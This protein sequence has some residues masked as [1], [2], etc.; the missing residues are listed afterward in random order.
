MQD[1]AHNPFSATPILQELYVDGFPRGFGETLAAWGALLDTLRMVPVNGFPYIQPVPFDVPGPDG[2]KTPE[3]LG[4]E[5]GRRTAVAEAAF[6]NKIWRD[7]MRYWDEELKPASIAKHTELGSVDLAK[8]DDEELRA[9]LHR[10]VEHMQAMWYQH[11]RYNG[12][13]LVPVADFCLHAAAWTGRPP[14]SLLA[15]FDGYSPVSS[16]LSPEVAPAVAAIRN[17]PEALAI[18]DGQDPPDQRLAAL[19][20]RLPEVDE[21][22]RV[23]G[24]RLA[25]GFDLNGLTVGELPDLALGRL[26]AG[27]THDPDES[28]RRADALVATLRSELPAEHQAEFDDLLAEGRL[29]YRLRDERGLYSDAAAVG[30]MRLALIELGTRLYE[31]G[32]IGFKYDALDLTV[33]EIDSVLDGAASPTAD[34]LAARVARRKALNKMGAPPFLGEPPPPP[35]PVDMLPPPLARVMSAFG[36]AIDGVLGE[37]EA[38]AG[39]DVSVHGIAGAAGVVEGPARLVRNFDDLLDIEDGDVIVAKATGESFNSFLHMA[40]AIV[41]D[42]GSYASHAAIMGREMGLPAVVG[43]GNATSRI[44]NGARIRVDGD[45]GV[46]TIL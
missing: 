28:K 16:V 11:H 44:P 19:R 26:E 12:H 30:L 29:V 10:C 27:L 42:H 21:Y 24:F 8:L 23:V 13:A 7:V 15:V 18:L 34:E 3:Y 6:A 25:T 40:V 41:T 17:D 43:T 22:M 38:P 9:H 33:A 45:S 2:P 32:R 36:F 14:A 37:L 4:A 39:D 1:R 5:I 35:P 31:R 46:V 20:A